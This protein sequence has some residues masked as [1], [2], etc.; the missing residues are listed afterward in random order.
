MFK[1]HNHPK[2][3]HCSQPETTFR[4]KKSHLWFPLPLRQN[5][6][7]DLDYQNRYSEY[8]KIQRLI[9]LKE[10]WLGV[11]LDVGCVGFILCLHL[12]R[13]KS[14][15]TRGLACMAKSLAQSKGFAKWSHLEHL[16]GRLF[17]ARTSRIVLLL[18]L[19]PLESLAYLYNTD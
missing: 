9:K 16:A 10:T 15:K 14:S 3:H 18:P 11:K 7:R 12:Q 19:W 2:K 8:P 17:Y 13:K 4:K 1:F 5:F 6:I